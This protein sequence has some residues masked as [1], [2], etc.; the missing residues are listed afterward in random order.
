MIQRRGQLPKAS[1]IIVE[2][3]RHKIL[4]E[5]L[6]IGA[7]LPSE[8]ELVAEYGL[9]R[10]TVR[11]ALR[12]LERDGLVDVR[13][14]PRG[15]LY[16]RHPD[17]A[18]VSDALALMFAVRNT[19]LGEFAAFRLVVEPEVAH[20]AALNATE[21]QREALLVAAADDPSALQRTVDLHSM[22]AEACG[23]YVYEM[24]LKGMHASMTQHFRRELI[25]DEDE[26]GTWR[27]HRKIAGCIAAGNAEA[28]RKAMARHLE[29][30]SA[31]LRDHRLESEPIVPIR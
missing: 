21:A 22:V 27:A 29:V 13:R 26:V 30:Y 24:V 4:A 7:R 11:E 15:G 12:M 3:V 31:Y 8:P 17:I 28:A 10:A 23:N 16:V 2:A 18:Q 6:P 5:R 1:D 20:L 9:G 19:T 25:T 14:G